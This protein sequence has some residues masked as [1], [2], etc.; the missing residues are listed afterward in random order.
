MLIL[1]TVGFVFQSNDAAFHLIL[2][3][4]PQEAIDAVFHLLYSFLPST[5]TLFTRTCIFLGNLFLGMSSSCDITE[6][7]CTPTPPISGAYSSTE[8]SIDFCGHL[9]ASSS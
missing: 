2:G 1:E 5:K 8:N 7:S 6:Y 3:K 9:N 4:R